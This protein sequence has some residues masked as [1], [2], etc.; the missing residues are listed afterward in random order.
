MEYSFLNY[1]TERGFYNQCTNDIGLEKLLTKKTIAYAGF[2]CTADS[3]HI[4]SLVQIMLLRIFQNFGHQ[5]IIL[6]GGGTSLI[7]DPSGKE[8]TRKI[9][10]QDK[11][12]KN[13]KN[14]EKLF[15][16]FLD[17]EN[18]KNGAIILDN[19]DWLSK[20]NYISF[21]REIGSQFSVNKMLSFESVKQRLRREQNLSFLEF[22]YVLFQ[23]FDFL[24]LYL[25]KNCKIQF[26]GSDQW[27]NIVSGIELIKKIQGAE[28]YGLTSP[29][30]TTASGEKMGKTAEGAI[31]LTED[32]LSAYEYWQF[33]RNVEDQDVYKF[34][35]LFTELPQEE[36]LKFKKV[37]GTKLNEAKILLANEATK[38]CHGDNKSKNAESTSHKLFT[39]EKIDLNIPEKHIYNTN[40]NDVNNGLSLKN[41]LIEIN[42]SKSIGESKRLISNGGVRINNEKILDKEKKVFREN[43][44]NE[45]ICSISFGKKKHGII[46][47]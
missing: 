9:L 39:Q 13:K 15:K 37:K 1:I 2:D 24:Q 47:F 22:N 11:I 46:K 20:L 5:P 12:K 14:L 23:S 28:V 33:W 25:K 44:N 16:K 19:F 21:L 27:G 40:I 32:K 29:L 7:G 45:N 38:I 18:K 26:G 34:L 4:G 10:D 30:I 17:F 35:K 43:F 8:E 6:L 36:I 31:W 3:L 42:F 41:I